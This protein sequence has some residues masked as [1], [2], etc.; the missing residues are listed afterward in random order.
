[1]SSQPKTLEHV[2]LLVW[3]H[4][5]GDDVEHVCATLERA[6]AIYLDERYP[7][8]GP[9]GG[10]RPPRP[11]ITWEESQHERGRWTPSDSARG[12]TVWDGY[13]IER[14]E[15]DHGGDSD[16]EATT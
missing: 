5:R 16:G 4:E 6:Q 10:Q 8:T 9:R 1:M 3:W 12:H 7:L 15:V 2:Y 13:Y 14:Y 11:T